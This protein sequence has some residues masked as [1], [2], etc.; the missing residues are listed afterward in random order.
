MFGKDVVNFTKETG[1]PT[2]TGQ[3]V[4]AIWIEAFG[5][6][7]NIQDDG[8]FN[9]RILSPIHPFPPVTALCEYPGRSGERFDMSGKTDG[10]PLHPNLVKALAEIASE[11][12]IKALDAT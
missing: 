6:V 1:T 7:G 8:G 3:F 5:D 10:I 11:L 2:N 9:F 4:A 12:N